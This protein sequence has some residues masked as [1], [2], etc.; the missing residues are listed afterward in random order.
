MANAIDRVF[1]DIIPNISDF[2]RLL[3]KQLKSAVDTSAVEKSFSSIDKAAARVATTFVGSFRAVLA[4]G[5]AA[6]AGPIAVGIAGIAVP[7]GQA[8]ASQLP[9]AIATS[10]VAFTTLKIALIGVGD[11]LKNIGDEKKFQES[12]DKLAPSAQRFALAL[13]TALPQLDAIRKAVQGKFFQGFDTDIKN[14]VANLAGPF[15]AGLTASATQLN[16]FGRQIGKFASSAK[17]VTLVNQ[18]FALT[19]ETLKRLQVPFAN[20]IDSVADF[21]IRAT[22]VKSVTTLFNEVETIL[23]NLSEAARNVGSIFSTLFGGVSLNGIQA[24]Q[25]IADVTAKLDAFL[26]SAQGQAVLALLSSTIAGLRDTFSRIGEILVTMLPALTSFAEGFSSVMKPAIDG[27]LSVSQS[28]SNVLGPQKDLFEAIGIA[29]G[30][31]TVA[32]AAYRTVAFLSA[33]AT[34]ALSA[35]VFLLDVGLA[36]LISPIALIVVAIAGFIAILVLA[37]KN[38][39]TFRTIVNTAFFGVIA[40]TLVLKNAVVSAFNAIVNAVVSLKNGIVSGFGAVVSFIRSVPGFIV[41]VFS[42]AGSLL[43]DAGSRIMRGLADGIFSAF[44]AVKDSVSS[45]LGWIRDA[46]PGS[47]IKVGPLSGENSPRLG[48]VKIGEMIAAGIR[49]TLPDVARAG[50]AVTGALVGAGVTNGAGAQTVGFSP[51]AIV[52]SFNGV[53]P[54][55]AEATRTGEAVGMGIAGVLARRDTRLAV[56]TV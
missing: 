37:Y 32:M 25:T 29:V 23:D 15:K 12:L 20:L 28:L 45:V 1:I 3:N 35:A 5:L 43:R 4:T 48:G 13:K 51:G 33:V 27:V 14:V 8:L 21:I 30:L 31:V 46:L 49:S 18:V 19:E 17:A 41:A 38:S 6:S 44:N 2:G 42:N 24:S 55:S 56:R 34:G 7:L 53:V 11:A 47:P 52:I 54:T 39:Q 36:I 9:A 10:V 50:S 26:K 40:A 22:E 16:L